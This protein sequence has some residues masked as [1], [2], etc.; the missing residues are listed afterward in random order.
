[1]MHCNSDVYMMVDYVMEMTVKK[2][3]VA[4]M[5]GLSICS[6][7]VVSSLLFSLFKGTGR[8]K[9]LRKTKER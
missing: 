3:C 8:R 7:C 1:M 5:D 6:S 9:R 4:N 2:F